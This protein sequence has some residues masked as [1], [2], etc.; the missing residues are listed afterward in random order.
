MILPEVWP[1][2]FI[3]TAFTKPTTAR[4]GLSLK[5]LNDPTNDSDW[6]L[7]YNPQSHKALDGSNATVPGTAKAKTG[8]IGV[9]PS[10]VL[11]T[12]AQVPWRP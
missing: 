1:C 2:L 6:V 8:Q 11:L 10:C 7:V 9:T 5:N 4:S 12:M 3:K